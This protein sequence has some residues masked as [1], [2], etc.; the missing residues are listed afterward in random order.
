MEPSLNDRLLTLNQIFYDGYA[1]SFSSTRYAIQPGIQKLL[2]SLLQ[3]QNILD[4]GCGN[5]NFAKALAQDSFTGSYTGTDN[6]LGLLHD[7]QR[8]ISPQNT[9]QYSFF[10]ADL[11]FQLP[12]LL[13]ETFF[14]AIVTFAVL[15][16]FPET[17][18]LEHF[19]SFARTHLLPGGQFNLSSWQ[20]KNN[21]RLKNRIQ[22]WSIVGIDPSSMDENDLLLDWRADPNQ[23]PRYRYVRHY[24]ETTLQNMGRKA[25]LILKDQFYS[26]GKEGN[27][28]L[29]QLWQKEF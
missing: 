24:D 21:L 12:T 18:Y 10:Q 2:P 4:L 14:D 1:Q 25:G 28:A 11:A 26:D 5:G 9:S 6:S 8:S 17:P 13:P 15:H 3:R 23:P 27:L 20:V 7:A 19:F 22:D 29:Y 16:H